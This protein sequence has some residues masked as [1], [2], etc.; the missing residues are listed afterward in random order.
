M[1]MAGRM[2]TEEEMMHVLGQAWRLIEITY[3]VLHNHQDS[4]SILARRRELQ[5]IRKHL[6]KPTLIGMDEPGFRPEGMTN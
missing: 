3:K 4:R 6:T 2:Y 1:G 5:A